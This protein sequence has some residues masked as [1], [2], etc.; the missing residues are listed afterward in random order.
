MVRATAQQIVDVVP[1]V[2][3]V[4]R[5]R[6]HE[7]R[8]A[9]IN[10]PQFRAL[11]YLNRNHGASLSDLTDHIGLTPSSMSKLIDGLVVRKL[12]SRGAC[13]G[14]RRR[15]SLSLTSQGRDELNAAYACT[16]KFLIDKMSCLP[17]EDL[18]S[19][20]RAMQVLQSLFVLEEEPAH[21][22]SRELKIEVLKIKQRTDRFGAQ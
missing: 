18:K 2:M 3:R 16:Q 9:D 17:E 15:I 21:P 20:F 8:A 10:V 14:D 22:T 11:L 12:V 19:I 7:R 6:L 5:A 4:I 13:S 1:P